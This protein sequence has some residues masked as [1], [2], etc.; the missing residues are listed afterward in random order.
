MKKLIF[1]LT[2]SIFEVQAQSLDFKRA[3]NSYIYETESAQTNNYGGLYIPVKKAYE[4]WANYNYLKTNGQPTPIPSGTPAASL[5]W[6]DVPGLISNV[7]IVAG[8][9]PAEAKI[10]VEVRKSAGKG[11]AVIAYKVND[12]I[13]WSWHIWVTDNPTNGVTYSQGFE[14]DV[15]LNPVEVKY[16]DR[17]LGAVAS[18]FLGNDWHKTGGLLYEWGRKDPFPALVYKDNE[19]YQITG[20]VG[21]L[22]HKQIDAVNT[23]PV[24]VREF[25]EI[26][27]NIQ[28]SVK[29][30]ITYIINSDDTGN[31]F[32]NSRYR[33]PG[34][35]TDYMTWDLW[36]DN[37]K[38]GNSNANSS[39]T[40]LKNES[41]SYE[42]KS[43]LDPC[44]NGWRIPSYYGRETQN[45]N[46]AF[47]G[48]KGNWNN[49][50][51][52]VINRQF[53]PDS[54]T[55]VFEGIKVYPGLGIDFRESAGG[56]RNIGMIPTSGAYVYYPNS[57]APNAPIGIIYQDENAIA[58]LWSATY[59]YDGAR[60]FSF[61]SDP[62]RNSTTVGLHALYNNQTNPTK[63]GN[64]VRC[65][66][67]PNMAKIGDFATEFFTE[68]KE[69]YTLGLNNPNTYLVEG[70]NLV[71]IPV[72]K[73]FAVH[74]Q[75]LSDNE[76]LASNALVA[77]VLW[78]T[79]KDLVESL[80]I[81]PTT[82]D[83]RDSKILV[84]LKSNQFGNAVISL[85]NENTTN[86]A[87]WS[88]TVWVPKGSPTQNAVKFLT[89]KTFSSKYNF[90]NPTISKHPPLLSTF[91]DRNI[92][93]IEA[94]ST[95]P[96]LINH[97]EVQGVHFQWG[98]K[99]ALPAF[100]NTGSVVYMG[101]ENS[102]QNGIITYTAINNADYENPTFSKAY[103][104]YTSQ[105]PI[106]SKKLRE[107]IAYSVQH[108][109]TFLYHSGKGSLYDG[110]DHYSNDLSQVRDWIS[111]ERA[112]GSN[113]WGHGAEKSVYDPCPD[114]WRVPD[115]SLTNLYSGSKGNSPWFNSS[116]NDGTNKPGIIQDQWHHIDNYYLGQNLEGK[117]WTFQD[118]QYKIGNF[119]K[120][121]T[122]G[123]LGDNQL[124]YDRYGVWTASQ[125]DLGTGFALAMQ[126]D[127]SN[128]KMQTAGGVYPQA[129]MGV[130]CMKDEPRILSFYIEDLPIGTT[131]G[132]STAQ[133]KAE[134][135]EVYPNPFNGEIN[136]KGEK[137]QGY[138]IY[139][140]AGQ[141][142]MTG[143]LS[144]GQ[145]TVASLLRGIY[146]LKIL[147]T[148]GETVAKKVI[149]N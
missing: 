65:M 56:I 73:A 117:G 18:N 136:V 26:E 37:A 111:N 27:K 142:I 127:H 108:P 6:E 5:Y 147:K 86:P 11:N 140:M 68:S 76:T 23:I 139:N 105:N 120:D 34:P 50:D 24:K 103:N 96:L 47:F 145:I 15:N 7:S 92:G 99:D 81:I 8:S 69:N 94:T 40:T 60:L 110:G 44:P 78:T 104:S 88:W 98:R 125:A 43:E 116:K 13:Y 28:Y 45:N 72:N 85:H 137:L 93:A 57:V 51:Q 9:T 91:M 143:N 107:N 59:G 62:F 83:P 141:K 149:K 66:K 82:G 31:W 14:T 119:A 74:N 19:F 63:T 67:D 114:G 129:A 36:A 134:K 146:L 61:V 10:K 20:E 115:V 29:N 80:Q 17:N 70:T 22:K 138:E 58:G 49:D 16:M 33:I 101:S 95:N 133:P 135:I 130:R 122:R 106:K 12:I 124:T 84:R 126:F 39:N 35:G 128:N 55:A 64:A 71:E 53:F 1:V 3:P 42:L 48:R 75:K 131:L 54:Q 25:D 144:S 38:G 109:L 102:S 148:N 100:A 121:G 113:R 79:N 87:Y 123:E 52:S 77:K 4:M 32:S 30:P 2:L 97:E 41:R 118:T 21:S 46:L 132:T 112:N 89:E 90:V